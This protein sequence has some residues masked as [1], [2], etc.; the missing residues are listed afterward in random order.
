MILQSTDF[1]T[2]TPLFFT[3]QQES[4]VDV[5][6]HEEELQ[7]QSEMQQVCA[8]QPQPATKLRAYTLPM[9]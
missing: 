4:S 6:E 3:S 9:L 5:A 1:L 2:R 7:A 8:F